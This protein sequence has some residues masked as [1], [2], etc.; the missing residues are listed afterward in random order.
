MHLQ[1]FIYT[2]SRGAATLGRLQTSRPPVFLSTTRFFNCPHWQSPLNRLTMTIKNYSGSNAPFG[3]KQQNQVNDVTT[4]ILFCRGLHPAS[5]ASLA[6]FERIGDGKGGSAQVCFS[7]CS[8]RRP[9]SWVSHSGLLSSN[10]F[11]E[12]EHRLLREIDGG[13]WAHWM[14]GEARSR[15]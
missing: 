14:Q 13:N 11:F 6:L 1:W 8:R 4:S 3:G 10:W 5:R 7:L 12:C 9:N 15:A 2:N